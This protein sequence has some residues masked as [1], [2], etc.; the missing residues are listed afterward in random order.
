MTPDER[1][2]RAAEAR[3]VLDNEAYQEAFSKFTQ[4]IRALR[5]QLSPRDAEGASRLVFMEQAVEKAKRLME[6]YL[7]DGDAARKELE[8]EVMPSPI[9]RIANRFLRVST[10][11]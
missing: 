11:F 4:D 9:G 7:Q 3:F 10:Q 6:S 1:I 5:L 8:A 2:E